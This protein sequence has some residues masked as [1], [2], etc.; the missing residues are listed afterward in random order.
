MC[1]RTLI[2]TVVATLVLLTA[3]DPASQRRAGQIYTTARSFEEFS[4]SGTVVSETDRP[5]Q[6][7][8]VAARSGRTGLTED[9]ITNERGE[10]SV[11]GIRAGE[12]QVCASSEAHLVTCVAD[13]DLTDVLLR[14]DGNMINRDRTMNFTM[15]LRN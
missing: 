5:L 7:V 13:G 14:R 1:Q 11:D 9:S 10:Y 12:Y 4:F 15:R 8:T 2:P 6:G 3:C